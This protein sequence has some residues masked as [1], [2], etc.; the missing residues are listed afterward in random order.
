[1]ETAANHAL[2][3]RLHIWNITYGNGS[4]YCG[5]EDGTVS[6][7]PRWVPFA[8]KQYFCPACHEKWV[9]SVLKD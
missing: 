5:L 8:P 3:F 4:F 2:S 9:A 7:H 1:V 6:V